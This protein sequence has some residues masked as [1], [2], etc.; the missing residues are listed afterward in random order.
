MNALT[1]RTLEFAFPSIFS[2]WLTDNADRSY[3]YLWKEI[4]ICWGW[5]PLKWGSSEKVKVA[6]MERMSGCLRSGGLTLATM[7]GV[8]G[9]VVFGLSLRGVKADWTD[10]EVMYVS[11]IGEIFLRM[12]K[13]LILPLIVPSLITAVGS[14]DMSLSGIN[15]E[16]ILHPSKLTQAVLVVVQSPITSPPPWSRWWWASFL[17]SPSTP[18]SPA[19]RR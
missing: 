4:L 5:E 6:A 1:S 3:F 16:N 9:G 11:Y 10:R 2:F 15:L 8:I 17:S 12:L 19:K 18:A 7:A 14:L 13:A